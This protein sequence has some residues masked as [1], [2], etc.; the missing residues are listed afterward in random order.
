MST[1]TVKT[2]SILRAGLSALNRVSKLSFQQEAFKDNDDKVQDL[3]GLQSYAEM[4]VIF[5]FLAGFLKDGSGLSPFHC[6]LMTLMRMRLNLPLRSFTSSV[7]AYT[8]GQ[9][10][11]GTLNVMHSRLSPLIMWPSKELIQISLPMCFKSGCY[12][13]CTSIRDCFGIFL[14]KPKNMRARAQTYSQ[15][16]HHDTVKYLISVTPQG[17]IIFVSTG[18]EGWGVGG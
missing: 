16:K 1:T 6:F 7:Q 10:F 13:K 12:K 3:T 14:E 5:T 17:V 4:M 8:V 15:H 11:N 18:W 9:I 2:P